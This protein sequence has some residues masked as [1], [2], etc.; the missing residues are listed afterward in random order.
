M[1]VEQ[2]SLSEP[3]WLEQLSSINIDANL[4]MLFI[5]LQFKSNQKHFNRILEQCLDVIHKDLNHLAL[6]ISS[7][8]RWFLLKQL[9]GEEVEVVPD[10][11]GE[12]TCF[13]GFYSYDQI[14][15][16]S[17]SSNSELHNQSMTISTLSEC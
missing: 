15:P 16:F 2:L 11:L 8:G 7:L 6:L 17:G 1:K 12:K 14:T 4:F 10:V 5:S 3:N 13:T 9:I